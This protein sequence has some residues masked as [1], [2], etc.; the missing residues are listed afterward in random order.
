MKTLKEKLLNHCKATL[1]R[2]IEL[3]AFTMDEINGSMENETKSSLGDKHETSRARMQS[4]LE[5]LSW[6]M[7]ELKGQN[8]LLNKIDLAVSTDK[9]SNQNLVRSNKGLFFLAIPLGKVDLD[10]ISVFV[11]SSVS[12]LGK[13][14][15][16][17][18]L[19]DEI[20]MNEV[21]YKIEEIL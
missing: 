1:R 6:Q 20:M 17:L 10:G 5:K 2:K 15:I 8:E 3:I 19:R 18:K 13:K 9:I 4:E 21:L 12:P 7:D 16:G 11:I 14:L